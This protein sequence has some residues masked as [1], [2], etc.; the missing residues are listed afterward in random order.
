M[1]GGDPDAIR[2]RG[3]RP[4]A[5]RSSQVI[6]RQPYQALLHLGAGRFVQVFGRGTFQRRQAG[7]IEAVS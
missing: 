1:A 7:G 2:W 4:S 3:A 6:G 5:G